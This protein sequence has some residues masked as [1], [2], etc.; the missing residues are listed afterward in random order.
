[1]A[2]RLTKDSPH[3][4]NN[5]EFTAALDDY[6]RRC[7]AAIDAG[8][9]RPV[10]S[11]YLGDCIIRMATRLS[12]KSNFVGYPYRDEM[13]QDAIL[14]AVKYAYRF[15]GDRYNN[16]FAFVTQI[17]FSHMVQRIKKEKKKYLLD[18][19]LI[20]GAEQQ[21]F[22]NPEFHEEATEKARSIADQKLQDLQ[23]SKV[24]KDKDGH[25]KG[26]FKLRSH[27]LRVEGEQKAI[28]E[29]KDEFEVEGK[30]YKV[31]EDKR[32]EYWDKMRKHNRPPEDIDEDEK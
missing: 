20:Q 4:V 25:S 6:S 23:E 8:K 10:M 5:K 7:R 15:N 17:L 3:Y 31:R 32:Q 1:M 19:K 11:R 13:V 22:L 29:H 26:G 18:L 9:E 14:A 21:L 12:L 24:G 16:G 28:S 27:T 30:H 2:K